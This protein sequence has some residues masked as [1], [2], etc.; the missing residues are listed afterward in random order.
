MFG[1]GFI[2]GPVLGGLLGDYWIRL[3]FIAAAVLNACNFL[4]ALFV[5]L[6]RLLRV[7]ELR[8]LRGTG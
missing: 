8:G 7:G 4:L 5:L 6:T 1:A 2:I 3:P